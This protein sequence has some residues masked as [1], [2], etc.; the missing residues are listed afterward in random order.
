MYASIFCVISSVPLICQCLSLKDKLKK[1]M[2]EKEQLE[3]VLKT[4]TD[5][6]ELYKVIL[7]PATSFQCVLVK[8]LKVIMFCGESD[9]L[10]L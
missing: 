3:C 8:G 6:K 1:V 10:N 7:F 5:E 9:K 2:L 4:E